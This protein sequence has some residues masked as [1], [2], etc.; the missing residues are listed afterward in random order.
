MDQA[1]AQQV[2]AQMVQQQM[3]GALLMLQQQQQQ[4]QAAAHGH[5]PAAPRVKLYES[6]R[7]AGGAALEAW[8]LE[9]DNLA[10]LHRAVDADKVA[11]AALHF[12]GTALQWW[13]GVPA[14]QRPATWSDLVDELRKR[15]LP[16]TSAE[17]ARA[18]LRELT[19]GRRS[20][21]EYVAA[22]NTLMA[23]VPTMATDDRVFAFVHGLNKDVQAHVDE[24]AHA[25]LESAVERA[26]RFG[27]R[28]GRASALAAARRDDTADMQMDAIEEM[29]GEAGASGSATAPRSAGLHGEMQE[30]LAYMREQRTGSRGTGAFASSSS[31]APRG[32]SATNAHS[33]RGLPRLHHLSP[34]EVREYMDAG[35]CFGCGSKDHQSRQCP[36]RKEGAGQKK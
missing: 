11:F 23:H 6:A 24:H 15:F 31:F 20:V 7:Y 21:I 12:K 32:G 18:Q 19:Q 4:Q 35:K 33:L 3:A 34:N 27:T 2:I 8:L 29:Y 28:N 14:A 26:V 36:T 17:L 10:S 9:I 16:I 1:A 25:S 30:L 5:Q 13:A 22:F